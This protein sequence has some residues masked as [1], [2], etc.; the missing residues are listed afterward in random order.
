MPARGRADARADAGFECLLEPWQ[1]VLI[2]ASVDGV[3]ANVGVSCGDTT[4]RGLGLSE[5]RT[6]ADA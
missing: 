1:V 3:M 6:L 4:K 5:L 2:C